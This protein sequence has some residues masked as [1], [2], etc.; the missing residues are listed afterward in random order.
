[1]ALKIRANLVRKA[2]ALE[3]NPADSPTAV[4]QAGAPS[5]CVPLHTCRRTSTFL[6]R[7]LDTMTSVKH[8]RCAS[9][10]TCKQ[11]ASHGQVSCAAHSL[12][13]VAA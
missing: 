1:M 5:L 12:V 10:L 9:A 6:L 3:T 2:M 8:C 4:R 11:Q 13:L 7:L